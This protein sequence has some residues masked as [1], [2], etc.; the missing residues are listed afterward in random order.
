MSLASFREQPPAASRIAVRR[1]HVAGAFFMLAG[2]VVAIGASALPLGT[3]M[4]MGPGYFP[5]L[6]GVILTG[7]GLLIAVTADRAAA[8]PDVEPGDGAW[9]RP[10]IAVSASVI[11]FALIIGH[12]GLAA[13]VIGVVLVSSLARRAFRLRTALLLGVALAAG[14]AAVFA[15]GLQLLF[16]VVPPQLLLF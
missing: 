11:L 1:D 6:L 2:A 15:Y 5:L 13:G 8:E 4:R 16:E 10:T 9:L 3:T 7:L 14:S 12:L